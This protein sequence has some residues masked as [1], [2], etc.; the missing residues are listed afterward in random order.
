MSMLMLIPIF[1]IADAYKRLTKAVVIFA[2][3]V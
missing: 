2:N 1:R 3:M